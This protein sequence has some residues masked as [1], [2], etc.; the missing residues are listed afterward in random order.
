MTVSAGLKGTI[1]TTL[2]LENN[3]VSNV[4]GGA[5]TATTATG[6]TY[7]GALGGAKVE[8]ASWVNEAWVALSAGKST[9]KLGRMELDTPLAFTETWTIEQ[10]SFEAAVL[11][12]QDLPDLFETQPVLAQLLNKKQL[13]HIHLRIKPVRSL[14][15]ARVNTWR[16]NPLVAVIGNF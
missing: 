13:Y 12:N 8:N 10:N 15:F 11:I 4:W 1:L 9:A 6:A 5:H 3:L 16:H 7:G 2:G 14:A